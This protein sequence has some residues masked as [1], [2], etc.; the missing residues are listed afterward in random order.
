MPSTGRPSAGSSPLARGLHIGSICTGL[1]RRIIPARAGFT[2]PGGGA[3]LAVEDHPRSRGVYALWRGPAGPHPG[4]SPLAR[5]LPPGTIPGS[6]CGRIIPARAG[7][8]THAHAPARGT[9]DH[10]RSR[11]VYPGAAARAAALLRIIP[12]RAGF[13]FLPK[14]D[15]PDIVGSSPLARGLPTGPSPEISHSRIIP[16]R[17]GFTPFLPI[18][19]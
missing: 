2:R 10:P 18:P 7:F 13:T 8:T 15:T 5:G 17:A 1:G 14:D 16:A 19:L 3:R 6:D 11:G 4:S 12:A 9:T